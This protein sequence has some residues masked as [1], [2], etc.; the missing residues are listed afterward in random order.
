MD[1]TKNK[2]SKDQ[3]QLSRIFCGLAMTLDL[4]QNVWSLFPATVEW[5]LTNQ[6]LTTSPMTGALNQAH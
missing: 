1:S 3:V 4:R 2:L 5:I 6:K